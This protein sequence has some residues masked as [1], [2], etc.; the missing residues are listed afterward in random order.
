MNQN[1]KNSIP[2]GFLGGGHWEVVAP[3]SRDQ[4]VSE[5]HSVQTINKEKREFLL[6]IFKTAGTPLANGTARQKFIEQG[7]ALANIAHLNLARIVAIEDHEDGIVIAEEFCS[8]VTLTEQLH[9]RESLGKTS[10]EMALRCS[11]FA[12]ALSR[13]LECIHQLGFGCGGLTPGRIRFRN[14]D[15]SQPVISWFGDTQAI[16]PGVGAGSAIEAWQ[17]SLPFLPPECFGYAN[18][19]NPFST[20]L[21]SIGAL[22]YQIATGRP[23]VQGDSV[24]KLM[25][26][27]CSQVP[28]H[29]SDEFAEFPQPLSLIIAR[30]LRK[31]PQV[32]Y[33]TANGLAGD[34]ER[35]RDC[36]ATNQHIP[37]FAL[38]R[39]DSFRE[40]NTGVEFV[41]RGSELEKIL[42][43]IEIAS[44]S[45]AQ[46]VTIGA[47]S[48]IG[49]SRLAS[50]TLRHTESLGMPV[51]STKYSKFE[52]NVPLSGFL[53]VLETHSHW[54]KKLDPVQLA[55]WQEKV[56]G[57]LG[58]WGRLLLKR[59][60][61]YDNL[62]PDFPALPSNLRLDEEEEFFT[63][64]FAKFVLT[65]EPQ[66]KSYVLYFDDIQWADEMSLRVFHKLTLLMEK[67]HNSKGAFLLA[68][69]R[70]EEVAEDDFLYHSVLKSIPERNCITLGPLSREECSEFIKN[71]LDEEE[72]DI[73][74]IQT[75]AFQLTEGN[76][77]HILELTGA[78][79]KNGAF[80]RDS[81]SGRWLIDDNKLAATD[82]DGNFNDLLN[83]R[84][85]TLSPQALD[86]ITTIAAVGS[87]ISR[88][89][90]ALLLERK[91]LRMEDQAAQWFPP[92]I[93]I[94][95]KALEILLDELSREH[96]IAL[97]AD[98]IGI[99]HDRIRES[100][101]PLISEEDRRAL[102][103]DFG[104]FIGKQN[105]EIR[106]TSK[107]KE[108]F[109]AGFHILR[110]RPELNPELSRQILYKAGQHAMN[111]FSY[112]HAE[113][114]L[115]V[116]ST[117]LE[118]TPE[119]F[120]QNSSEY[121]EW[122]DVRELHADAQAL[123]EK[124][125][126]SVES[127]REILKWTPDKFRSALLQSKLS[128]SCFQLFQY[129]AAMEAGI[130]GLKNVGESFPKSQTAALLSL[131]FS[132]PLLLLAL[133]W[134]RFFATP[135][136]VVSS[137]DD[138]IRWR[139]RVNIVLPVFFIR[140]AFA[141]AHMIPLTRRALAYKPN[142]NT[143]ALFA[144]WGAIIA[145]F[146]FSRASQACHRR[147][148]AYFDRHPSPVMELFIMFTSAYLHDFPRGELEIA[149][150]KLQQATRSAILIGD[151]FWR[152]TSWQGLNHVAD[153]GSGSA[154]TVTIVQN[155]ME[156]HRKT[157]WS[158]PFSISAIRYLLFH[159]RT[160]EALDIV[161]RA[162]AYGYESSRLNYE[163]IDAIHCVTEAAQ[164][165]L[166]RNEP[167]EALPVLELGFGMTLRHLQR[168]SFCSMTPVLLAQARIRCGLR[169]R[170]MFPLA[171]AWFNAYTGVRVF[172]PQTI[173]VTAELL[174]SFGLK[175]AAI[176][177]MHAA[178]LA[179]QKNGWK[180]VVAE[181]QLFSAEFLV[182]DDPQQAI[183]MLNMANDYFVNTGNVFLH[184][185]CKKALSQAK[186][187][188]YSKFPKMAENSAGD[189]I[190]KANAIGSTLRKKLDQSAIM[191]MLAKLSVLSDIESLQDIILDTFCT[192]TGANVGFVLMKTEDSW[193]V[194]RC[195]NFTFEAG[196]ESSLANKLFDSDFIEKAK[197][198]STKQPLIREKQSRKS[199]Q[200]VNSGSSLAIPLSQQG[201]TLC[202]VFLGNE[203]L[204]DL[205]TEE[206]ISTLAPMA[207]QAAI[208]IN[209]IRLMQGR[210]E[211][212][213]MESD[214]ATA[215][216]VQSSIL[217][218]SSLPENTRV[219]SHYEP[220]GKTGGDWYGYYYEAHQRIVYLFI[221]DA[222]GHGIGS[223]L[224]A[225]LMSGTIYGCLF[226]D[227]NDTRRKALEPVVN[228]PSK[229][230]HLSDACNAALFSTGARSN[231]LMTMFYLAIDVD[232]G[233]CWA[234]SAGH[235]HP[236]HKQQSEKGGL[237]ST[238]ATS[239]TRV[240]FLPPYEHKARVHEFSLKPG[241]TLLLY[242]DGL[243]ENPDA[244]GKTLSIRKIREIMS[245]SENPDE[246]VGSLERAGEELR[247][248]NE[249]L[250]D[251]T[252]LAFQWMGPQTAN[253]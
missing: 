47:R 130:S 190:L 250:D 152:M 193:E 177:R 25:S 40:L 213:R 144:Y 197:N 246:L 150:E 34:L 115:R 166:L 248:G 16:S 90:L 3:L 38:G 165:H 146:G 63:E 129:S 128:H 14:G 52:R 32:R 133:A 195:R 99:V 78:V 124:I 151:S 104:E 251:V 67:S 6:R 230:L 173:F 17:K 211:Q 220:A 241:D 217:P 200:N 233:T 229:L 85:K 240:G 87:V 235:T 24:K 175:K 192:C 228:I 126:E 111:V 208:A 154:Q 62:L 73:S 179:A 109:E 205:F 82:I 26:G 238:I 49:K 245:K 60:P 69:Y 33:Q 27:I 41:G 186:N 218:F 169:L 199:S 210:E 95:E 141:L 84:L 203:Q 156:F 98:T 42:K 1:L 122:L 11:E 119:K 56:V 153:Y 206:T 157:N 236:L 148:Q 113:E 43:A 28:A 100:A 225:G 106:D 252:M 83:R 209:N 253:A 189:S 97:R 138:E 31:S 75:I 46:F 163:S 237:I 134:Y 22:F 57:E 167:Q 222:T 137:L 101:Y 72:T 188:F 108:F 89:A 92:G 9:R 136:K 10:T 64:T 142:A 5:F 191:E 80:H 50:E 178:I 147:A 77:L 15:W 160:A 132:I 91:L 239:G 45:T 70:S 13:G 118:K 65:L 181:L 204:P 79:L 149:G 159:E 76:P 94:L 183:T 172:I 198:N 21:Y 171:I 18:A 234:I 158:A 44:S 232:S 12:I 242:T 120:G 74:K 59:I 61:F 212:L 102:H 226:L 161:E 231:V 114:F 116:A 184:E 243:V 54:L 7:R 68:T 36:L 170:A 145:V 86:V 23:P 196:N 19:S 30:L 81:A 214:L 187:H 48:G 107:S 71:L 224:V 4:W 155:L 88:S 227:E 185:R 53:R 216:A 58:Q 37:A 223:A 35:C 127:Y 20:D 168:T 125:Q 135:N 164:F 202:L 174:A 39:H 51:F 201:N 66:E 121:A 207:N 110:G 219:A 2:L 247:K 162:K 123:A 221:G 143:A 105:L 139:L 29:I 180:N 194:Q 96:L 176:G 131:L 244:S 8:L 249:L 112:G 140:P 93:E 215:K 117:L 182:S 55:R 103:Q